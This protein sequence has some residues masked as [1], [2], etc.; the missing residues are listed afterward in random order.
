M[1]TATVGF[2]LAIVPVGLVVISLLA[3]AVA[4]WA[5]RKLS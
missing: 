4:V 3:G 1:T 5:L 2:F